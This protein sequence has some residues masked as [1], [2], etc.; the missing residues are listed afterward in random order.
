MQQVAVRPSTQR[1]SA[2]A[3]EVSCVGVLTFDEFAHGKLPSLIRYAAMLT[4]DRELA[5]DVVQDVLVRAH[6]RWDRIAVLDRPDL[7]V[8]R[9]V[10]NEYF[11]WRRRRRLTTV[12]LQPELVDAALRSQP[13][14]HEESSSD[15]DA[16]WAELNRLP[17]QQRVVLVLRF[18]EG[19]SDVE[20]ATVLGCR[21]P[22]VRGYASRA[23]AALRID[24]A[25]WRPAP[26]GGEQ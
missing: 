7:Y 19:L 5:E 14:S 13:P 3:A 23:L 8:K 4:H 12:A 1:D 17:R 9:M 24:M 11:T 16:L 2:T 10:T 20:I 6:G 22:T 26:A 15:R 25:A 21:P 18:Y